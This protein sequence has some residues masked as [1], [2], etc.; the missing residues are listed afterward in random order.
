MAFHPLHPRSSLRKLRT[1]FSSSPQ[2]SSTTSTSP[3]SSSPSSR[4]SF[5]NTSNF[6]LHNN[7]NNNNR[8]AIRRKKSVMQLEQGDE[9]NLVGADVIS[10][11]VEPRPTSPVV[12]GGIEEILM[13]SL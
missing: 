2:P 12:Y 6:S 8:Q 9:R 10:E 13:G 5:G 11:I 3:L 4:F 7:N 1:S